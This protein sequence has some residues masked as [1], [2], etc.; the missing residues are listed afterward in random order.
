MD[1]ANSVNALD[2]HSAI[3]RAFITGVLRQP[4]PG[5][6]PAE[7]D[8]TEPYSPRLEDFVH[9]EKWKEAAQYFAE[10]GG[11]SHPS[12]PV[13]RVANAAGEAVPSAVLAPEAPVLSAIS[14]A[15]GGA[16]S[17]ATAEAGG[18]PLQQTLAGLVVGSVPSLASG[19]AQGARALIRNQGDTAARV[20]DAAANNSQLT[21]GQATGSKLLQ[22]VEG[23]SSKVWGGGPISHVADNQTEN[24]GG[25]ID[26]VVRNLANGGDVSPTGAGAAINAGAATTKANMKAAEKAAYDRVDQLV[27]ADHPVDVSGTLSKLDELATP[28]PSAANTTG[29][30]VSPKIAAM[31]DNLKADIAANGGSP[32][33]PYSTTTDLRTALGNNIDW[34]FA[35]SDPVTNGA[36]KQIHGAL[37]GDIDSA[38]SAISPDA[39][40]AVTDARTLY[41]QNQARRDFLN[42]VIDK[43]GGPEAVY[44]AATN[45]TRQGATK[46]SGVMSALD[47]GQQNLV[48]ATVINR[49]GKALPGMQN[50]EGD[51][52]NPSTFLTN[53]NKLDPAAKD[54]LFGAKGSTN[55]LRRGLDSFANTTSTIRNST[56]YKNPSGTAA[57]AGHGYGLLAL[58]GEAG[59]ALAGHPHAIAVSAGAIAGN[60]L[61][62]RALTNPRVV[63][64]LAQSAKLPTSGIP[65][66]V[67]QL[68]KMGK[69]DPDAAALSAV[70]M[71]K[72]NAQ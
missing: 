42:S 18:S 47:T 28:N 10:K 20:A 69:V 46:I 51:A 58:L 7:P 56:L 63:S 13:E 26:S 70:L 59:A 38:A 34:G 33:L 55:Q 72:G 48:R 4:D 12:T 22:R 6:A 40:Q 66:A 37:K 64:W 65:N 67:N 62:A 5:A 8:S 27:P 36:L 32:V 15:A 2:P 35:P 68:A 14:A 31:R 44:A 11:L 43:A 54:A 41:A 21:A 9:P 3:S 30:L 25:H 53:W 19:A 45:G 71:Q 49:L 57:A 39:K 29:A 60:N 61:L 17:Q 52:F 23:A 16:A 50:A 24:L 1:V